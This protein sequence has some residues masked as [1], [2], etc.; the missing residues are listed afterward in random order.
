M[1]LV[2]QQADT[3]VDQVK[4]RR[5]LSP[6]NPSTNHNIARRAHHQGTATW[7]FQ[8]SIYN[9]WKSAPSLLWIYGKRAP[10]S[11]FLLDAA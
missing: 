2:I 7:F 4:L 8:G 9:E 3:D 10:L 1:C 11:Q 5:W 6:A